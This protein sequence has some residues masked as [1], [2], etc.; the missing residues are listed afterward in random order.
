MNP[1]NKADLGLLR[2]RLVGL[3]G[4]FKGPNLT[5]LNALTQAA[6]REES[7]V[8]AQEQSL[9]LWRNPG[10]EGN[11]ASFHKE[12]TETSDT[13]HTAASQASR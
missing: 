12:A 6:E 7:R 5:E 2:L 9:A 13:E 11:A 4:D 3:V 10:V 8:S 1:S